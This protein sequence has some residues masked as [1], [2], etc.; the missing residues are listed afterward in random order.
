VSRRSR[1]ARAAVSVAAAACAALWP[2][3]GHACAVC[4]SGSPKVRIAF[5]GTTLLLTLL[6]LAMI[7]AGLLWLRRSGRVVLAEEFEESDYSL[8]ETPKPSAR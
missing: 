1:L 7:L 3:A 5:F 6:P 8:G 4:F 2:A